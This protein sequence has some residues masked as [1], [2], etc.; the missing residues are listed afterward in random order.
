MFSTDFAEHEAAM[1]FAQKSALHCV[2][3]RA[4]ST[5][6]SPRTNSITIPDESNRQHLSRPS[7]LFCDKE[8][9]RTTGA[10]IENESFT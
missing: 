2:V 9:V 1:Y 10:A 5:T 7:S 8:A 4:K 3:V 6:K